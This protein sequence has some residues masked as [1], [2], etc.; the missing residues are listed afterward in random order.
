M[1]EQRGQSL[2]T[3]SQTLPLA[4]RSDEVPMDCRTAQIADLIGLCLIGG[5]H[6]PGLERRFCGF[7]VWPGALVLAQLLR[8]GHRGYPERTR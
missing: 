4:G 1:L 6:P 7:A 8:P 2:S 3:S 5:A